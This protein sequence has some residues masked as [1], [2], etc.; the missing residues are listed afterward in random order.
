MLEGHKIVFGYSPLWTSTLPSHEFLGEKLAAVRTQTGR[1]EAKV[2]HYLCLN[3]S[4]ITVSERSR[5]AVS[6]VVG[7]SLLHRPDSLP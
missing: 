5:V 1:F 6:G 2:G 3:Q 4:S 7:V